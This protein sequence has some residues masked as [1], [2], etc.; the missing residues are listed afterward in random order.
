MGEILLRHYVNDLGVDMKTASGGVLA[1]EGASITDNARQV[2]SEVLGDA[3]GDTLGGISNV[4]HTAQSVTKELIQE[5][6][7]VV[8]M[9]RDHAQGVISRHSPALRYTFLAGELL[10][11]IKRMPLKEVISNNS[12]TSSFQTVQALE[13]WV[14]ELEKIREQEAIPTVKGRVMGLASDE[15]EDPAIGNLQDH[16][17]AFETINELALLLANNLA[18]S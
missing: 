14:A 9:T 12:E 11:L 16:K 17:K 4:E 13:A 15:V 18:S 6:S 10:R 7:L 5:A 3:L 2:L 1:W 8:A